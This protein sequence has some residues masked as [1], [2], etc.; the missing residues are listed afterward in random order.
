MIAEI[1]K[2]FRSHQN[3]VA[4]EKMAAYMKNH[5]P[6]LGIP[7]PL[8][9]ELQKPFLKKLPPLEQLPSLLRQL[10]RMDEREFQYTA[11]D[12]IEKICKKAPAEWL[13][14]YEELIQTKSWWDTVD[15]LASKAVGTLFMNYPR[16]RASAIENWLESEELWLQ[17]TALL[18]QLKY[19]QATDT[20]ILTK[21]IDRLKGYEDFFIRK[22][23]GWA[24]REYSKTDPDWVRSFVADRELSPLS[25]REAT[26]RLK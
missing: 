6:F 25:T 10:W 17:R 1:E 5:F 9:G 24:L 22:A 21:A 20:A 15:M 14:L 18:F 12:I 4:A 2:I 7:R 8:R 11:L 13:S 26:K 23:I 3:V 16:L 19:K